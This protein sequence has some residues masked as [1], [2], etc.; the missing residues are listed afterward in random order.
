MQA[1]H[2]TGGAASTMC[3]RAVMFTSARS[4]LIPSP[5][6]RGLQQWG[7]RAARHSVGGRV[8]VNLARSQSPWPRD[9]IGGAAR[10]L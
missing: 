9:V 5:S 7:V 2:L 1:A 10:A 6:S 8:A 4:L 3:L